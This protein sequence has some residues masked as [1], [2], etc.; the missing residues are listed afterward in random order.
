[1]GISVY[2]SITYKLSHL[3]KEYNTLL[4]EDV[5]HNHSYKSVSLVFPHHTHH[6]PAEILG[7]GVVGDLVC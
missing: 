1:M 5:T 6:T 2:K 7:G 3:L 4:A